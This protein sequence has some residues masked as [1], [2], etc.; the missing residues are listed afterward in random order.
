MIIYLRNVFLRKFPAEASVGRLSSAE[1]TSARLALRS[2]AARRER[3]E[4]GAARRGGSSARPLPSTGLYAAISHA[5]SFF[6]GD[7]R[8]MQLHAQHNR[9]Q[10]FFQKE[11]YK[12]TS[13]IKNR[14]EYV[15]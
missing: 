2:A 4:A 10:I 14:L 12:K 3:S 5:A 8:T 15:I 11:S 13:P 6:C 7:S 9:L 1:S